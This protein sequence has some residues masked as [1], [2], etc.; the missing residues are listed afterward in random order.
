M[1]GLQFD[2]TGVPSPKRRPPRSRP[3][4]RTNAT[5]VS[6]ILDRRA[7]RG[8]AGTV[9]EA[10]APYTEAAEAALLID[11]LVSFG[12][13]VGAGP[14]MLADSARHDLKLFAVIIGATSRARKERAER[15]SSASSSRLTPSGP[16]STLP[17]ACPLERG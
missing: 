10:I 11:F 7:L 2:V 15:T 12:N 14:Y 5:D 17:V 6:P 16:P 8:L 4:P 13:A 1:T 3:A 9:V